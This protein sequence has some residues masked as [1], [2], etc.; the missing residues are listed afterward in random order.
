MDTALLTNILCY[1]D[2]HCSLH[3]LEVWLLANLQSILDSGDNASIE[4]ANYL[5]A[6]LIQ[7]GEG[8]IEEGSVVERLRYSLKEGP[9]DEVRALFQ[10]GEVLYYS[11]IVEQTGLDLEMVVEAC[12]VLQGAGEVEIIDEEGSMMEAGEGI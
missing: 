9:I 1:L 10:K 7:Y 4:I 3:K 6:D 5:D 12:R 8:L 11:D 2:G